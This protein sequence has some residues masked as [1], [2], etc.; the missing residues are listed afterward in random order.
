LNATPTPD[1]PGALWH[2]AVQ[3]APEHEH[4]LAA[5]LAQLF[6]L[7]PSSYTA[8]SP[9]S[10]TVSVYCPKPPGSP[11]AVAARIRAALAE[12]Q[13][14][15]PAKIPCRISVRRLPTRDWTAFW[16]RHFKP[17]TIGRALLI[18]PPW[19]RRHADP[20]QKIVVLNPG[21]SFGTGH[22]PT[23]A[24]C[25]R[26]IARLRPRHPSSRSI[27]DLGCG[28]GILAIAAAKLGYRP[29]DA[30]DSDPVAVRIA[31]G[32]AR[33]NRVEHRVQIRQQDLRRLTPRPKSRFDVVCA[34]L[35]AD[36]LLA[37]SRRIAQQLNPTGNLVLAGILTTEF[38]SIQRQFETLGL[39]LRTQQT[40]VEWHSAL[41][42]TVP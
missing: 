6:Q 21:L 22:H 18:L 2:I 35:S 30:M 10:T 40:G 24:F 27:L 14:P 31:L 41:F 39:S 1:P 7:P 12:V 3:A 9:P 17:I 11:T 36:L 4:A 37:H 42:Q 8:V 34:N 5:I 25:L 13:T 23:T 32:N 26:Q 20:G 15:S 29:V 16:Q 19:I 38:P 33:R 28:S